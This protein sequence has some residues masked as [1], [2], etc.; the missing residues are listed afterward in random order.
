MYSSYLNTSYS[1]LSAEQIYNNYEV[2]DKTYLYEQYLN[3]LASNIINK[4]TNIK[5]NNIERY[6]ILEEFSKKLRNDSKD[7]EP[8]YL[9]IFNKN[10]DNI[11]L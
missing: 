11:L 8:E 2:Y 10:Y 5:I 4:N 3:S 9:K 6:S 7:I 1:M